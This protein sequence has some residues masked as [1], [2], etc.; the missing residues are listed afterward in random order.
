MSLDPSEFPLLL[1]PLRVGAH[2]LRNR[3]V[4][5]SMHMRLE[6]LD[7][8]MRRQQAFYEARAAGGVALVITGGVAPNREGVLEP[9][10]PLLCDHGHAQTL[11]PIAVAVKKHGAL[12]I[13]QILHAGRYAKHER[14]VGVSS[15]RSPIN[16]LTPRALSTAEVEQTVEDFVTCA[17]LARSAGFDG[18]EIMGSE[19]YLITQFTAPRTNIRIDRWGG[20][21][22]GRCRFPVEV[23]RR[24]RKRLG[25]AFLIMY[26]IS[27]VD[28]V[29]QGSTPEETE[30]L[31][32]AVEAAGA[33]ILNTGYGWH[34]APVPTIAYQTPRAAW[35]FGAAR[36][37]RA[38]SI[39]VMAS[40]RINT[41]QLAES[42]LAS[43][44]ADLVS[45]ARPLLA[46]PNFVA[47]AASGRA[48]E[49][50]T[51]IACNQSCLDHIFTGRTATCLVNPR[52]GREIEF[53]AS[54][55]DRKRIAVIGAGPAG[56][57]FAVEAAQRG[58]CVTL[59]EAQNDIGGQLNLARRI[60]GKQEFNE[61]LRYFRR[62]LELGGVTVRVNHR[63]Q[64][65]QLT[66]GGYD[67]IVV[68]T[69]IVPREPDIPGIGHHKVVRYIDVLR[70]SASIGPRVAIIGAGGIGHDVAEFLTAAPMQQ[71]PAE[72]YAEWGVDLGRESAGGLRL[73]QVS[74]APHEITLLR[75]GAGRVGDRL[76]KSTGWIVRDRLRRRGVQTLNGVEYRSIDDRGLH[77]T[78]NGT[79][80]LL[81]VDTI[82]ICV[83]QESDDH[84]ASE[85]RR[86]HVQFDVIGGASLATHLDAARAIREGVELAHANAM[87][88]SYQHE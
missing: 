47:K 31:A 3:V 24:I 20:S 4:M 39:P 36:L 1:T 83:G 53:E 32:Q 21:L 41:P 86:L 70:E 79:S 44:S 27:A 48:D 68:A 46:D 38:V 61:L 82:V 57:A 6:H 40:N 23:T 16:P 18:V 43:S 45:M 7:E 35:T 56:L 88:Q 64:A 59:F 33:D 26:R 62:Q 77:Y 11:A 29:E 63:V 75:R 5:G 8:P 87:R 69:G 85:L 9:G 76:G 12:V 54:A 15:L 66:D 55:V 52:A 65:Q 19:G 10:G 58:H 2:V 72:F 28:L 74:A 37:K 30:F 60:P 51:C 50:N 80:H 78:H 14:I 49:I 67:R 73:A 22:E 84:L 17:E 34:E 13:L 71:T 81:E 42:I 25:R